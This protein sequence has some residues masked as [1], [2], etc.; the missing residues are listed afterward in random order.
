MNSPDPNLEPGRRTGFTQFI[1]RV[2][3]TTFYR[4]AVAYRPAVLR[5][6]L[7]IGIAMLV[8]DK[9]H[10]G[11]VRGSILQGLI[12]WRLFI[13]SSMGQASDSANKIA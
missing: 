8:W 12:A 5:G 7:G 6:A 2:S 1:K 13:D 10:P 9:D 4:K 3:E 11:D